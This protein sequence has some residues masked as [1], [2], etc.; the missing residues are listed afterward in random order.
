MMF[1]VEKKVQRPRPAVTDN[2]HAS[3]SYDNDAASGSRKDDD[4]D[5]DDDT[6]RLDEFSDSREELD[7]NYGNGLGSSVSRKRRGMMKLCR[8]VT[9]FEFIFDDVRILAASGIFD[10]R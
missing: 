2:R 9:K 10:I 3:T 5:E 7:E 6:Q 4:D 8:N 1:P